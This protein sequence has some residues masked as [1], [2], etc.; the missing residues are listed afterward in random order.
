V[1]VGDLVKYKNGKAYLITRKRE[2]KGEVVYYFLDGFSD[3]HV[4]SPE[5][6]ELINEAR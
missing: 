5:D 4:F 2:I 6:L 1:K 3:N